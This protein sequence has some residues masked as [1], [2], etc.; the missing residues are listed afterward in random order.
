MRRLAANGHTAFRQQLSEG[1]DAIY[2]RDVAYLEDNRSSL[3]G[4]IAGLIRQPLGTNRA[5]HPT[6][7]VVPS[8]AA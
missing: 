5:G 6:A 4:E 8:E 1:H 2:L 3:I 7:D